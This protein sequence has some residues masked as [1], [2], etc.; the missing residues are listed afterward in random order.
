MVIAGFA[1]ACTLVIISYFFFG[2]AETELANGETNAIQ[3]E[4]FILHIRVENVDEGFQVF[5]ALQYVG[6]GSVEI[7]HHTPLISVSFKNKNHDYTGSTV[8]KSLNTGIS[9]HPQSA[10]RFKRPS[11]GTYTLF[12][13]ASFTVND[14]HITIDHQQELVFN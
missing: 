5:R 14:Q 8:T 9:Y 12:C 1:M 3:Q 6:E 2:Q 7:E 11:E 4:D 10:K 13:E